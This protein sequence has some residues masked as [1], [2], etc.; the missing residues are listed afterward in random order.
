MS[1]TL[2]G[3]L[4]GGL[5]GSVAPLATLIFNHYHWKREAK[6]AH[7]KTERTRLE[8]LFEKNLALLGEAMANNSYPSTMSA[9]IAVLMPKKVSEQYNNFMNGGDRSEKACKVVYLEIALAMNHSLA[10]IDKK[11]DDFVS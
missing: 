5:I 9:E 11:I 2:L 1:E 6:L 10:T 8:Q 4:I 7:L 3:V